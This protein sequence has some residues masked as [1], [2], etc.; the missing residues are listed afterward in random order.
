[1][2]ELAVQCEVM[3]SRVCRHD[4]WLVCSTQ[5]MPDSY[6][7]AK[8]RGNWLTLIVTQTRPVTADALAPEQVVRVQVLQNANGYLWG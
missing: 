2:Q 8:S 4:G 1:M 6:T 3:P 5:H 7:S